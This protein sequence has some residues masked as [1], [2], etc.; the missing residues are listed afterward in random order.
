[1]RLCW[2][3]PGHIGDF[4]PA[5]PLVVDGTMYFTT[6]EGSYRPNHKAPGAIALCCR[7]NARFVL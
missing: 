5:G 1:M 6:D 4:I 2:A 3:P 7:A